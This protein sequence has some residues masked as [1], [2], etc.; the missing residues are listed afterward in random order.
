[1]GKAGKMPRLSL[2][3]VV[4]SPNNDVPTGNDEEGKNTLGG[5]EAPSPQPFLP[6]KV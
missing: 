5:L 1:M 2:V 6:P 4:L 3:T